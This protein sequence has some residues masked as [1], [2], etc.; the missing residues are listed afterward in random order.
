MK[1]YTIFVSIL[2]LIS[3]CGEYTAP[4]YVDR[5]LNEELV[6]FRKGDKY[7]VESKATNYDIF[8][9]NGQSIVSDGHI[10]LKPGRDYAI[11]RAT[12]GK[13]TFYLGERNL[14]AKGVPNLRD[15]GGHFTKNGYQVK[16]SKVFRSGK[17]SELD[18]TEYDRLSTI[19]LK[20]IIDFRGTAEREE[21]PDSWP[22]IENIN[23]VLAPIADQDDKSQRDWMSDLKKPDFDADAFMY[24]GN[25]GFILDYGERYKTFFEVLLDENNYPILYHCSA[26]KDRAGLATYLLL[27]ALGVDSQTALDDYLLSNYYLQHQSEEDIKKAAQIFGIDQ[28]KLRLLMKVKPEFIQGAF[29]A[30]KE[31]YGDTDSYLCQAL[32]VCE[33]EREKLKKMLLYNY[34]S[35]F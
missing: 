18:K 30:I 8:D 17:L 29:D 5:S 22:G 21:D 13:D 9:S 35:T 27:S 3:S 23:T 20:T 6:L 1:Y 32:G 16:W 24:K 7:M 33:A 26:G 19:G 11:Y 10:N 31:K 12:T 14:N 34:K 25:R 2:I 15:N 4:P 28:D